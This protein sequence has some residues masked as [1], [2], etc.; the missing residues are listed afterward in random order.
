MT[1]A[2]YIARVNEVERDAVVP[3]N[4]VRTA[5]VQLGHGAIGNRRARRDELRRD[6]FA[7][8]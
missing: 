1:R 2:D 3:W 5:Y 7:A 8:G 4:Q 6:H